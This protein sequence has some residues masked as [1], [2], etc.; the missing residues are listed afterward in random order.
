MNFNPTD[1]S[2]YLD[3]FDNIDENFF[4]EEEISFENEFEVRISFEPQ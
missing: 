3:N 2:T 4:N 1:I